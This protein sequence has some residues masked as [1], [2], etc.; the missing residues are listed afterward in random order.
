MSGALIPA[1]EFLHPDSVI[2]YPFET[3]EHEDQIVEHNGEKVPDRN[4]FNQFSHQLSKNSN[5]YNEDSFNKYIKTNFYEGGELS[6]I[7][8]NMRSIPANLICFNCLSYIS[9]IDC[10][11]FVIGFSESWL[12]SSAIDTYGIDGYSHVRLTRVSGK[13]GGVSLFIC[14]KMVYCEMPE[15]TLMCDYIE[16]GFCW[17][18]LYGL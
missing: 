4:Y 17:D 2:F 12:N 10:D 14:D 18:Q 7:H 6:F 9:Y 16:C 15:L 3:N 13:G 1:G 8:Y 11:F 5:Y